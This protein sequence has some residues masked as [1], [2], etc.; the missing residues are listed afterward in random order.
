M[1]VYNGAQYVH[2]AIDSVLGQTFADFELVLINDAS[3]DETPQI[4]ASYSDPRIVLMENERNIGLARSLNRGIEHSR[5]TYI[6]RQ[7]ADDWSWPQRL[8]AQVDF[9]DAHPQVGVVGATTQWVN[10]NDEILRIWHQPTDHAGIQ[11]A[12]L[13]YC[14]LV[15]GS[16]MYRHQAFKEVRGYDTAMR[17]GQDY[18]LWLRMSENWDMA[19]LPDVLYSY[20]WHSGMASVGRK[21]EQTRNAQIGLSRAI[22]RRTHYIRLCLGLGAQGMPASL[23]AMSRRRL[24]RRY[25]W[26]SAG[27]RDLSRGLATR[28]LLAALAFDPTTPELWSYVRAIVVRKMRMADK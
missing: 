21:E 7:D 12:L 9:L 11:E 24:A 14:C 6:A 22:E 26:W 20:R 19:C 4:L 1:G 13:R 15:H 2:H 16:T 27:A 25:V 18:D 23:R 10:D 28:F 17:T 3:T 5:G 8:G